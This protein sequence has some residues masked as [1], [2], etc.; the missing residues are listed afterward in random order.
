MLRFPFNF[1]EQH[2]G[3]RDKST[4]IAEMACDPYISNHMKL[5][6]YIKSFSHN[7]LIVVIFM[8]SHSLCVTRSLKFQRECEIL[9]I[10]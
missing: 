6:A 8:I 4:Q 9:N 10:P 3:D 2:Q 5:V 7:L 1:A